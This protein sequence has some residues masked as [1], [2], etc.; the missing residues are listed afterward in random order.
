MIKCLYE[1]EW[2]GKCL[3]RKTYLGSRWQQNG[4]AFSKGC[5]TCRKRKVK[6]RWP[7]LCYQEE[8]R[9]PLHTMC[10]EITPPVNYGKRPWAEA[11]VLVPDSAARSVRS[12]SDVLGRVYNARAI[13]SQD[14]ASRSC[15]RRGVILLETKGYGTS[16][17]QEHSRG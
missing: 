16:T 1:S 17:I 5:K 9:K 13:A 6:V 3:S 7:Q 15:F 2:D 8:E 14:C 12:V 10:R 11:E 4:L